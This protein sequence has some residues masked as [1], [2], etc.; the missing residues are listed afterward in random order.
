[1]DGQGGNRL[2]ASHFKKLFEPVMIGNVEVKN[3]IVMC[4]MGS[5]YASI[6]GE[7]TERLIDYYTERARGGVGMII[8]EG[9]CIEGSL[10]RR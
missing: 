5:G 3:R 4:P 8:V 6:T 2:I 9:T 7:V 1:M 10:G